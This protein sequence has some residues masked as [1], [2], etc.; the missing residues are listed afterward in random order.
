MKEIAISLSQLKICKKL[1]KAEKKKK[2]VKLHRQFGHASELKLTKLIQDSK[3][4]DKEFIECIK[5]VCNECEICK[6]YQAAPPR[7]AVSLPLATKFNEVVCLDLKEYVHNKVWI[8]H[9]IDAATRYSQAKL[10]KTKRNAEYEINA[11]LLQ[12]YERI[13]ANV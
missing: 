2:A 4:E 13:K 3:I 9:M 12:E 10:I 7:P 11:P 8:L 6:E 1:P 5:E